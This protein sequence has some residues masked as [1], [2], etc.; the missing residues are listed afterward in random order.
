[1]EVAFEFA[2]E[3]WYWKGPAPFYFVTVPAEESLEIKSVE[4]RVSYGW[5][6]IPV[7]VLI[8]ASRWTTALWPKDGKYILPLKDR[9]RKNES[10][11]EGDTVHVEMQLRL[12]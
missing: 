5:G 11:H 9:V 6:M 8:G 4:K 3:V 2:G 7:E 10:I 12:D 1:M